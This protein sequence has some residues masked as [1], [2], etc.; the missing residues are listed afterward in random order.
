VGFRPNRYTIDNIFINRLIFRKSMNFIY[1]YIYI[2]IIYF[3]TMH[4]RLSLYIGIK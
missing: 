2:C 3:L 1:I 4:R